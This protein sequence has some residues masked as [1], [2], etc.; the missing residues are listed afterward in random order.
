M[1]ASKES[2][3]APNS[4]P[5]KPAPTTRSKAPPA[6]AA[7]SSG[8]VTPSGALKVEPKELTIAP[9]IT[10]HD[11][12]EYAQAGRIEAKFTYKGKEA[13]S[14]TFVAFNN[15]TGIKP[16][17]EL[18]SYSA[19]AFEF[20]SELEEPYKALTGTYSPVAYT[21]T[22]AKYPT[23]RL[24]DFKGAW[25]VYAGDCPADKAT[26]EYGSAVVTS[27]NITSV[28]VPVSYTKLS[29]YTGA[30][31]A[32]SGALDAEGIRETGRNVVRITNSSC[33]GAEE[34]LNAYAVVNTHEQRETLAEGRLEN[35]FQPF[36]TFSL[37][38]YE[39]KQKRN[40][41]TSYT[42]SEATGSTP[43]IYL[44]QKTAAEKA[45]EIAAA[46]KLQ[47][48][49]EKEENEAKAAKSERETDEKGPETKAYWEKLEKEGKLTKTQV[50]T[51]ERTKATLEKEEKEGKFNKTTREKY[52]N[53][54]ETKAYWEKREKEGK[55]TKAQLTEK[56]KTK[57]ALATEETEATTAKAKR[58]TE[59]ATAKTANTNRENREKA[60]AANKVTVEALKTGE[61][62]KA[63]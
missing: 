39:P 37:C 11:I 35:P 60:E 50:T 56:E 49:F 1:K 17:Y 46:E 54:A 45:E 19:S 8:F 52:E 61:E 20:K 16:E 34:P 55:L 27:G 51:K 41:T 14:D 32:E 44:K 28:N 38:L 42:N 23:G 58:T 40:Y 26:G 57:A 7:A 15:E 47:E 43:A 33:T 9:N 36:G 29:V 24:F 12:V 63:C 5:T 6:A 2:R 30:D 3:R 10:T 53:E 21:A 18:G 48:K 22:G 13:K 59:E 4:S 62:S 31:S 25:Q